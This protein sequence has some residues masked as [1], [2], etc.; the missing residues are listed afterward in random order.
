MI[1]EIRE[2]EA[3]LEE[4]EKVRTYDEARAALKRGENE[5]IPFGEAMREIDEGRVEG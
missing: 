2:H 4:L 3:L 1:L 5:P